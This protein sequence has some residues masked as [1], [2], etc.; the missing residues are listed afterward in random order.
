MKRKLLSCLGA[1]LAVAAC[2]A[3]PME[4]YAMQIFVKTLTGKTITLDVEPADSIENV[5]EKI[6]DKEGIPTEQQRL[7]FAGRELEDGRT[8]ADYNIQK[9]STLHLVLKLIKHQITMQN[10]GN[11]NARASMDGAVS[12]DVVMIVASPKAGYKFK[13]WTS[14]DGVTFANA[15]SAGTTFAMPDNAVTVTAN[16][17]VE[18]ILP[19]VHNVIVNVNDRAGGTAIATYTNAASD[20]VVMIVASPNAGYKFREWTTTTS[21]VAFADTRSAST[22]F[23]MPDKPVTVKATFEPDSGENPTIT[24]VTLDK[25]SLSVKT[26]ETGTLT[27]AVRPAGA[28]ATV[29]WASTHPDVATVSS[30][31]GTVTGRK[32]GVAVITATAGGQMAFCVVTVT[33]GGTPT[34]T[35]GPTSGDATPNGGSGGGCSSAGFG[36]LSLMFAAALAWRKRS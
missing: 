5:K 2:L 20:D 27:A 15:S 21:G 26:G 18:P 25:T 17:E 9:E 23:T 28:A 33:D 14:S 13:N 31:S 1:L 34:P 32:A 29:A 16:F 22:T 36:A 10:D 6:K 12:D 30:N 3:F 24:G 4:A 35:P 11:G 8:L 19:T 7:I